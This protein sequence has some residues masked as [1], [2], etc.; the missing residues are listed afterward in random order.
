LDPYAQ[1]R[2][3][4]CTGVQDDG[5]V[6]ELEKVKGN[7]G[8]LSAYR[9]HRIILLISKFWQGLPKLGERVVGIL[10]LQKKKDAKET[11]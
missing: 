7:R 5:P 6:D 8:A 11:T 3:I 2:P 9:R 4:L 1:K 10:L